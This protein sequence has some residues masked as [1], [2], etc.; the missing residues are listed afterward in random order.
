MIMI[1]IN[2][3]YNEAQRD[4]DTF[5]CSACKYEWNVAHELIIPSAETTLSAGQPPA[6]PSVE[7]K[8]KG[9]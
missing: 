7:E 5:R 4:G 8:R 1:C 9:K 6:E 3:G 2:C